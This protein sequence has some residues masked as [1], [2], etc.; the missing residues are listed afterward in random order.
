MIDQEGGYSHAR[1][2][3]DRKI[4]EV[5]ERVECDHQLN[6]PPRL[7]LASETGLFAGNE[8]AEVEE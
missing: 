1:P 5:E 7:A 6:S 8:E 4:G 3:L 2:Y